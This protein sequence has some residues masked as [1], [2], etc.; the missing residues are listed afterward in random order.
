MLT[1]SFRKFRGIQG[2][3]GKTAERRIRIDRESMGI[4]VDFKLKF[5]CIQERRGGGVVPDGPCLSSSTV[6]PVL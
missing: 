6:N 1:S 4:T 3:Q 5:Y 2:F